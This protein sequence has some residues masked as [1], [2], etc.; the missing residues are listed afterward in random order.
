MSDGEVSPADPTAFKI[1]DGK[2][3][4]ATSKQSIFFQ[5]S[6]VIAK[7]AGEEWAR[8]DKKH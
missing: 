5:N 8:R 7:R 1:I 6:V 4:L 2:L 3:Y